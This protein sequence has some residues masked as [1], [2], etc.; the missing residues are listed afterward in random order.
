MTAGSPPIVTLEL[1]TLL[2]TVA[3]WRRVTLGGRT[4]GEALEAAFEKAPALRHHLTEDSGEL[5]PHILCMLNDAV[6]PRTGLRSTPLESGDEILIH[7]AI[8]GG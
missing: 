6:V 1:P 2:R 7:Q 5:R 3:G 4:I 8:S